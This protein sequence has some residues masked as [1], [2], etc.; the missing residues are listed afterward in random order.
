MDISYDE[1]LL[2]LLLSVAKKRTKKREWI[3]PFL[4]ERPEMGEFQILCRELA[5]D[6]DKFFQHYRMSRQSFE[7]L[8]NILKDEISVITTNFRS[9]ITSKERLAVCL[10]Y[11]A[12]GGSQRDIADSYRIGRSTVSGIVTQ[13][14]E[15]IWQV[16]QPTYLPVPTREVWENAAM[17]FQARWGF[18]NCTGAIE[19]KH[20]HIRRPIDESRVCSYKGFHSLVCLTV[21]DAMYRFLIVDVG[22]YGVN[23]EN[24]ILHDSNFIDNYFDNLEYPQP[25][26]LPGSDIIVPYVFLGNESFGL[27]TFLMRPYPKITCVDRT[28]RQEFN[29]QLSRGRTVV[30]KAFGMLTSNWK[31]F[32]KPIDCKPEGADALVKAT[33]CLHNFLLE[34]NSHL[35]D[36]DYKPEV[37]PPRSKSD[38]KNDALKPI[39]KTNS[40]S[41]RDALEVRDL[42]TEYFSQQHR[43]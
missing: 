7:E 8:H 38:K 26:T 34:Q 3:R 41:S 39:G 5:S 2:L 6:E 9:S 25:T 12:V 36:I 35:T 31:V 10:R 42:F 14:C 30:D 17:E 23:G 28:D 18:P 37:Q 19:G 27:K 15:K 24:A 22:N 40:R 11:L 29:A 33:C 1:E 32:L 20:V 21:I 16:L 4:Q 13:V 43:E